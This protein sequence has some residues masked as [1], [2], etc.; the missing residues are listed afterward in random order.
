MQR[1][2]PW[3]VVVLV[4]LFAGVCWLGF[5]ALDHFGRDEEATP[6]AP[7]VSRA[8]KKA[9]PNKA[10][11]IAENGPPAPLVETEPTRTTEPIPANVAAVG[12]PEDN[13]P[14]SISGRVL[15]PE[16]EPVLGAEVELMRGPAAGLHIR[17]LLSET[18][19]VV[20]TDEKG[21]Y[22]FDVIAP[23][24]D[25]VLMAAH[26]EFGDCEAGQFIVKAREECKAG[27]IQLRIGDEVEG[28]VTHQSRP[29]AG[30][31]ITLANA[32]D[33]LKAFRPTIAGAPDPDAEPYEVTTLTDAAGHY[34]F[35][36]V[37][38]S[39]FELTAEA[40]GLARIT[41][42]PKISA[43]G[44]PARNHTIDF[45]LDSAGTIGGRVV[46][47]SHHGIAA[48]KVVAASAS[49]QFR[50]EAEATTDATGQFTLEHLA[51]APFYLKV[52]CDGFS[53]VN[54]AQVAIGTENLEIVL[55]VQ[56]SVSGTVVDDET[57]TAIAECEL[58]VA[59]TFKGRGAVAD[60]DHTHLKDASG[61]FEIKGLDPGTYVIEGEAG[62][63]ATSTS[64]EFQ[65]ERGRATG[66]VVLRMSRG[67]SIAVEVTD[68]E[69]KPLRNAQVMVRENRMVDNPLTGMLP[70]LGGPEKQMR[71]RTDEHGRVQ[72]DLIVPGTYQVHVRHPKFASVDVNDVEVTKNQVKPVGKIALSK[73]ARISGYAYD[74]DGNLLKGATIAA[75]PENGGFTPVRTNND[76][77]YEI[78]SLPPGKY[79][80]TVNNYTSTAT[81]GPP[82]NALVAL[83]YAR[84]SAKKIQ[85]F[86]SD[87]IKVELRLSKERPA[88]DPAPP[89][90][91]APPRRTPPSKP[92][93]EEPEPDD[94][95]ND[96]GR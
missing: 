50:C 87:D 76:G 18:G 57:G 58:G 1:S 31:T 67:G 93:P 90:K 84:N 41:K 2:S 65:I 32:M 61:R 79:T 88:G 39:S 70:L 94:G 33:R 68:P 17:S 81:S 5:R 66:G 92:D 52:E 6:L 77:F 12:D 37:P 73:G 14:G 72:I 13:V 4:A 59:Q 29:V 21:L 80:V 22:R 95:N 69:G 60:R 30:A 15:G 10:A 48:A 35:K 75:V 28:H 43:F 27:D 46:D 24:D 89:K 71:G 83:V 9:V 45:E 7:V 23:G 56:G 78:T 55:Q 51:N 40:D 49:Q 11:P 86:D 44:A 25:Y 36:S 8:P 63:Y 62:G 96:G 26:P 34:G 85:L 64:E 91:P 3:P 38:V 19:K 16:L 82:T 54:R 74:L 20:Q 53:A 47:E 42:S